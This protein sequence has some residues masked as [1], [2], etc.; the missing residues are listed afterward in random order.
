[1]VEMQRKYLVYF[2]ALNLFLILVGYQLVTSL[3][4]PSIP[5]M[6]GGDVDISVSRAVTVPF[7]AFSLGVAAL[8]V[9]LSWGERTKINVPLRLY[10]IY[11]LF[12]SIRISYDLKVRTDIFIDPAKANEL[13]VYVFLVCLIPTIAV[14]RSLR[15]LDLNLV[16]KIVFVAHILLILVFAVKNPLLFSLVDTGQR[17]SGNISLNTISLG[18]YGV[19]LALLALFR[20]EKV[21]CLWQ[22]VACFALI[23][24]GGFI[25]L[26]SGSRGPLAA[27]MV[28]FI[29]FFVS[30]RE[31]KVK[32]IMLF[33]LCVLVLIFF[34]DFALKLIHEISPVTA[35]RISFGETYDQLTSFTTGRNML[36]EIAYNDF[37]DNPVFGKSFAISSP[38]GLVGYSHNIIL[39]AF[40]GLGLFGG[41]LFV[42]ILFFAIRNAYHMVSGQYENSWIALLC[43]Q[44]ITSFMFSGCFYEAGSLNAL[45]VMTLYLDRHRINYNNFIQHKL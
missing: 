18:Q 30:K 20:M 33:L 5:T 43:I 40:M 2:S 21:R 17:F 19:S 29:F 45:L 12:L 13:L 1:M 14:Y 32:A 7:R 35:A 39:D 23:L 42:I 38:N 10:F 28:C 25:M 4:L 9:I 6:G 3:F 8:V 27:M 26:R 37:L 41:V 44:S 16:F 22:K 31:T 15:V 11:W 34:S 36:Y 24:S